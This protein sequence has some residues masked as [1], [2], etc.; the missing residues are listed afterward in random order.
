M[1]GFFKKLFS[2]LEY[3]SFGQYQTKLYHNGRSSQ[4]SWWGG[5]LSFLATLALSTYAFIVLY[6]CFSEA[7]L[8]MEITEKEMCAIR[9]NQATGYTDKVYPD[10]C[11]YI[12]QKEFIESYMENVFFYLYQRQEVGRVPCEQI[13]VKLTY[14]ETYSTVSNISTANFTQG[15]DGED[16]WCHMYL[17][18]KMGETIEAIK[19]RNESALPSFSRIVRDSVDFPNPSVKA[20]FGFIIEGMPEQSELQIAN[21]SAKDITM[22][23]PIPGT[24]YSEVVYPGSN[25]DINFLAYSFKREGSKQHTA[26]K[27]MYYQYQLKQIQKYRSKTVPRD[28]VLITLSPNLFVLYYHIYP[29]TLLMALQKIGALLALFRLSTFLRMI[30]E[31]QFEKKLVES[32]SDSIKERKM[33][34]RLEGLNISTVNTESDLLTQQ[35]QREDQEE[36]IETDKE[37]SQR[38]REMKELYSFQKFKEMADEI[39]QLKQSEGMLFNLIQRQEAVIES[40][41]TQGQ[42]LEKKLEQITFK[43]FHSGRSNDLDKND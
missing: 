32:S 43:S 15:I 4:S 3:T 28:T 9:T 25:A 42:G 2:I 10:D 34:K 30:H 21:P 20:K 8:N 12:T 23:M 38:L 14:R 19:K 31:R 22:Q 18:Q 36:N 26:G 27:S 24:D 29:D 11:E 16:A 1:S 35:N 41:K 5:L 37:Q 6:R 13:S 17:Y 39:K 33:V 40:L 7:H